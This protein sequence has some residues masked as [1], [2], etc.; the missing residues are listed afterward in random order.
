MKKIKLRI[1]RLTLGCAIAL[2]LTSKLQAQTNLQFTGVTA[3]DE[4]NMRLAWTSQPGGIYEIDEA[5]SL[6]DTNTGTTTWNT[7]YE[8]YPSQGT[9]TFWLD[10]GNYFADPTILNPTQM[11]MRF[12][13]V[14][15]TGTNTTPTIPTVSIISPTNSTIANGTIS[16]TVTASSD[17]YFFQPN[18]TLTVRK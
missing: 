9:N 11:P 16:V 5:D 17:Q 12:Y 2:C 7:L 1:G 4:G 15:L 18:F 8:D 13:C 6:I 10:T 14:V 3:T